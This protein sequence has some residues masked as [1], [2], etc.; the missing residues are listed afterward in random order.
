MFRK[1]TTARFEELFKAD[2]R[3]PSGNF[4]SN[5]A[6]IYQFNL[7]NVK[8]GGIAEC[9]DCSSMDPQPNLYDSFSFS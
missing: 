2:L 5:N 4:D 9:Y 3:Y 6:K 8:P 1:L 7:T